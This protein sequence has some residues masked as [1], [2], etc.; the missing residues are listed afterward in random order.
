MWHSDIV[1][2]DCTVTITGD[3]NS[4]VT[5]SIVFSDNSNPTTYTAMGDATIYQTVTLSAATS[6]GYTWNDLPPTD[7]SG[8]RYVYWVTEHEVNGCTVSYINNSGIRTGDITVTNNVE[9]AYVL[10]ETG[11]PGVLPFGLCGAFLM[12]ASALI[13]LRDQKKKR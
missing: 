12:T 3:D 4:W 9:A 5:P 2:S 7:A 11:G 1:T 6:W 8:N 13:V 10:P